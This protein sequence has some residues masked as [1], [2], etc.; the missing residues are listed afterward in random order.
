MAGVGGVGAIVALLLGHVGVTGPI[1]ANCIGLLLGLHRA[2]AGT[3]SAAFG[4]MQFGL[5]AIARARVGFIDGPQ[6]L[7]LLVETC[8]STCLLS[9]ALACVQ[10]PRSA[11]NSWP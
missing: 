3:A 7:G 8:G 5:G 11:L 1:G 2:N 10:T 4:T 6:S 9:I